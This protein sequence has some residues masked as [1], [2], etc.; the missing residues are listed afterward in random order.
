MFV[1]ANF[2]LTNGKILES[3][4]YC[5]FLISFS[6]RPHFQCFLIFCSNCWRRV[7]RIG[8]NKSIGT[9]WV[10]PFQYIVT[11]HIETSHLMCTAY[12]MTGFYKKC[13]T[14]LKWV[15]RS[16]QEDKRTF[17]VNNKVFRY[18]D[19]IWIFAR[20]SRFPLGFLEDLSFWATNFSK[21]T[22]KTLKWRP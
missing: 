8:V 19:R 3:S 21:S 7:E 16:I 2:C 4:S 15:K 6:W 11:F 12:Q 1:Q 13:N 9:K 18:G 5:R 17:W 20:W 22:I 14:G 10:N